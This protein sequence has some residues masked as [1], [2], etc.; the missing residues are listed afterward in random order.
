M[1]RSRSKKGRLGSSILPAGVRELAP[2][3]EGDESGVKPPHSEERHAGHL[4]TAL[5]DGPRS[6]DTLLKCC[7]FA[8][9]G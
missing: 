4:W 8:V 2:A 9:L 3:L 5:G 7:G 1:I 6:R